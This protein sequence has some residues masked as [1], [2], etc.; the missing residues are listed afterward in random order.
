MDATREN[1][2]T[3]Y[4]LLARLFTYPLDTHLL[5][6]VKGLSL[7]GSPTEAAQD[8]AR[9]LDLMQT[10]LAAGGLAEMAEALNCEA[11]RLFEGPGQPVAPP[12]ASFYLNG[13][14]LVGQET[15]AVH[16]A[17]LAA[18]LSPAANLP[19]D[20]LALELG[21]LAALAEKPEPEALQQAYAFITEHT[22]S[23]V[24]AWRRQLRT[25]QPNSFFAG[26]ADLLHAVLVA[27]VTWLESTLTLPAP[28]Q[29]GA[30]E[31]MK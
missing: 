27:D 20:H 21:F 12:F 1:R 19:A 23:W 28:E 18:G 30:L 4:A 13:R 8:I 6:T 3:L 15:I 7:D 22:L 25:A 16:R 31:G 26:L 24:P 14:Q 2:A 9:G 11:T 10:A 5:S 29:A 17:Y